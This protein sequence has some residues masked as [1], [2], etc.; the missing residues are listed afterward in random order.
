MGDNT[1]WKKE[2]KEFSDST[3]D[4]KINSNV[5]HKKFNNVLYL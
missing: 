3:K 5:A 4:E 2:E 1:R